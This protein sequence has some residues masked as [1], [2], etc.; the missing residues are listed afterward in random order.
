MTAL[1]LSLNLFFHLKN[2]CPMLIT[3]IFDLV[4]VGTI[5]IFVKS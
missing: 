5:A 2:G 4:I 3:N 1:L